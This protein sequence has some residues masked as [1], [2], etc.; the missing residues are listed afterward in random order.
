METQRL[1][2]RVAGKNYKLS[3]SDEPEHIK[4]LVSFTNRRITEA[5]ASSPNMDRETAAVAAALSLADDLIKAQDD[6]ARLR[7]AIDAKLTQASDG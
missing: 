3:F 2:V 7:R 1:T 4:R 6:I 5:G